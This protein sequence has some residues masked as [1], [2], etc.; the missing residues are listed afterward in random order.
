MKSPFQS[1]LFQDSATTGCQGQVLPGNQTPQTQASATGAQEAE[2]EEEGGCG[3][4]N[5]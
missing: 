2:E 4:P 1:G 5:S 3:L